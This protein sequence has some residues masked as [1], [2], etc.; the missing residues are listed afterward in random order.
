MRLG[1]LIIIHYWN[2]QEIKLW[3][4]DIICISVFGCDS[5]LL[6]LFFLSQKYS[7][8]KKDNSV[9]KGTTLNTKIFYS[10]LWIQK[11]IKNY[12]GIHIF[13]FLILAVSSCKRT[14]QSIFK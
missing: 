11:K 3:S 1:I 9:E 13:L 14:S 10:S 12:T 5:F 7:E 2:F 6:V 8:N 4:N